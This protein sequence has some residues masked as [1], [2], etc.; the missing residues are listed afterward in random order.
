[1]VID[2]QAF[3]KLWCAYTHLVGKHM[4]AAHCKHQCSS[5]GSI[6]RP[7][8]A[9]AS[10]SPLSSL[11]L[12]SNVL[13]RRRTRSDLGHSLLRKPLYCANCF[14]T[15]FMRSRS[16]HRNQAHINHAGQLHSHHL[17]SIRLIGRSNEPRQ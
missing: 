7:H 17:H 6:S 10:Q 15:K 3:C 16:V 8:R 5:F 2:L 1:M 13:P 12:A 9:H 11:V 4:C 14:C